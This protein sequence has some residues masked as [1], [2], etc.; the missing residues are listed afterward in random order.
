MLRRVLSS[1]VGCFK[2][3]FFNALGYVAVEWQTLEVDLRIQHLSQ[4]TRA[5]A[6][7]TYGQSYTIRAILMGPNGQAAVVVSVWFIGAA[8]DVPRFVTAYPGGDQ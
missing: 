3:R 5:R 8:R 2:A 4:P 1:S 6:S 7:V